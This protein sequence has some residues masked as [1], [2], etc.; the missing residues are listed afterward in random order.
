MPGHNA[1]LLGPW[2]G[3][4]THRACKAVPQGARLSAAQ[5][6]LGDHGDRLPGA[7]INPPLP[8]GRTPEVTAGGWKSPLEGAP[9]HAANPL[10]GRFAVHG[11]YL[12]K[13]C[14]ECSPHIV[15]PT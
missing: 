1:G 13:I 9:G 7:R 10:S 4:E 12:F 14:P 5:E 6:D 11:G 2:H 3:V 15:K 8:K